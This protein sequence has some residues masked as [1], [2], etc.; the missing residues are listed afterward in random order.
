MKHIYQ[1]QW[2]NE[3]NRAPKPGSESGNKLRTYALFKK[4][5]EYEMYLDF[6]NDFRKRRLITKLRI[7]SHR[8]E[9]E[10]GIYQ[11]KQ[12]AKKKVKDRICN[13]CESGVIEDEKHV[14]MSCTLYKQPREIMFKHIFDIF[15]GLPSC[16]IDEQ[17]SF[18]MQCHDYEVFKYFIIMLE[19]VKSLRGSL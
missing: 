4:S 5:F 3:I 6:N 11:S 15:P 1:F 9:V 13:F 2:R 19:S 7:S 10:M 8:L 12:N 14:L 17:F 18:I 16:Y